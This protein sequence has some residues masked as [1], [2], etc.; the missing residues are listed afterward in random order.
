MLG[1]NIKLSLTDCHFTWRMPFY[2]ESLVT[3]SQIIL[4]DPF[5]VARVSCP[6]HL[7]TRKTL[8]GE[9]YEKSEKTP[10]LRSKMC[11]VC[12]VTAVIILIAAVKTGISFW[13]L[14]LQSGY[15]RRFAQLHFLWWSQRE[16]EPIKR[17]PIINFHLLKQ[18]LYLMLP[19]TLHLP[20]LWCSITNV[21]QRKLSY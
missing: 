20:T 11:R 12:K 8:L 9:M 2:E 3:L 7:P 21:G 14:I 18:S 13:L 10:N 19:S 6:Y 5:I 4:M 16:P 17:G 1:G 15:C